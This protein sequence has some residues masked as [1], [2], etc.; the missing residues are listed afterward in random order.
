MVL[1]IALGVFWLATGHTSQIHFTHHSMFEGFFKPGS[2]V[3]LTAVILTFSGMEIATA[4]AQ[5]VNNPKQAYPIALILSVLIIFFT[6]LLGSLAIAIIVPQNEL[7]LVAGIMQAF[8]SFFQFYGIKFLAPV[9]AIC[10]VIGSLG[11]VS[12]W[13]I[14]PSRGLFIALQEV[15]AAKFLHYQNQNQAP[16]TLLLYQALLVTIITMVFLLMPDV[17]SSYW[18]LT[19]LASQLYMVMYVMMFITAI[20]A[21]FKFPDIDRPFTIPGGKKGLFFICSLGALVSI[22]NF[23]IG[24]APPEDINIGDVRNYELALISGL[25]IMSC[26]PFFIYWLR[27]LNTPPALE[28]RME[29]SS[30]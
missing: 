9:M 11:S 17:N 19:V 22:F 12:N 24:F 7:S 21:R 18:Y 28:N 8:E 27:N 3:S 2:L 1:I 16:S 13:I 10:I 26:P 6:M 30:N 15:N 23:I 14:A 20:V 4:H 25:I 5:D 29:T